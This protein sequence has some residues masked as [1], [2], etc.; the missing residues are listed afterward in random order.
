MAHSNYVAML[1]GFSDKLN[2]LSDAIDDYNEFDGRAYENGRHL[3]VLLTLNG[4]DV[5][6]IDINNI[7][8]IYKNYKKDLYEHGG[9]RRRA[10]N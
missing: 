6:T 9:Q 7:M 3:A 8:T 5:Q 2:N 1:R 10:R 4:Y